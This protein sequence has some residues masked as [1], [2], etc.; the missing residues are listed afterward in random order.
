M[1]VDE[2]GTVAAAA[3]G[4][5]MAT[6]VPLSAPVPL[7]LVFDRPF[8]FVIQHTASHTPLFMGVVQDPSQ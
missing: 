5:G 4:L 3:T 8:I 6:S 1:Q 7:Q 2:E